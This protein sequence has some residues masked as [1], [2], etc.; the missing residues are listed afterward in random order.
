MTDAE[1][2]PAIEV[3]VSADTVDVS[4]PVQVLS[5]CEANDK[6]R[7]G[8]RAFEFSSGVSGNKGRVDL[9]RVAS[10]LPVED[11]WAIGIG[12]AMGGQQDSKWLYAGIYDGHA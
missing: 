4:S 11:E 6:L 9:V 5:L 1:P 3:A 10:N 12:S 2:V 7:E 8:A